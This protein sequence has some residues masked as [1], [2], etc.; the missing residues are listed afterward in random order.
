MKRPVFLISTENKT[1]AQIKLE[2]RAAVDR[3]LHAAHADDP[4]EVLISN[5]IPGEPP[6]L[7]AESEGFSP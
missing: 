6:K 2:A 5:E 4:D 1:P 7:S 3:F